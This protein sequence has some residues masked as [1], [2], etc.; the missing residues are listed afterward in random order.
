MGRLGRRIC[1][2]VAASTDKF[3][4]D[5]RKTGFKQALLIVSDLAKELQIEPVFFKP[6]KR[7]AGE[8]AHNNPI[9]SSEKMFEIEFFNKLL[10]TFFFVD[11][12]KVQTIT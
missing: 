4:E 2:G 3:L 5:Y 6:I 10:D 9:E 1:R 12:R 7:Q 11:K 8:A